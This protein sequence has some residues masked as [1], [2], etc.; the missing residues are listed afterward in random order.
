MSESA[1][2]LKICIELAR[3]QERTMRELVRA[4][5]EFNYPDQ[6]DC[7]IDAFIAKGEERKRFISLMGEER[8]RRIIL[9]LL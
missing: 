2:K 7:N 5:T 1:E 4:L 6:Y 9:W 3:D 8:K